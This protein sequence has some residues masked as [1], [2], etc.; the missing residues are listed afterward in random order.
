MC[1]RQF[2][3]IYGRK[4]MTVAMYRY[5]PSATELPGQK[6]GLTDGQTPGRYIVAYRLK[7]PALV[8]T[9]LPVVLQLAACVSSPLLMHTFKLARLIFY[10]NRIG[11]ATKNKSQLQIS[12]LA[13]FSIVVCYVHP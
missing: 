8:V 6:N 10:D 3:A 11:A 9:I 13:C 1:Q 2:L 12:L 5:P 7:R 4:E